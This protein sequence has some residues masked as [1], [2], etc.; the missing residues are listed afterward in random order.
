[1]R[2]AGQVPRRRTLSRR[3]PR[4]QRTT[5]PRAVA[6]HLI[7]EIKHGRLLPGQRLP[8]EKAL[9]EEFG[10]GRSSI[11]E[12]LQ[13]LVILGLADAKPGYGY[14]IKQFDREALPDV[15]LIARLLAE[16]ALLDLL[17]A[18]EMLEIPV[19]QLAAKRADTADLQAME[20]LLRE[21]EA[22]LSRGQTVHREAARFHLLVARAAKNVT[23]ERWVAS[24]IPLLTARG[25][26]IEHDIPDRSARELLLHRR[27]YDCIKA[28]D[29]AA[30]ESAMIEHLGDTRATILREQPLSTGVVGQ[31]QDG[32][33]LA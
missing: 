19:A 9:M 32:P 22:K 33:P 7:A 1:V 28:H 14:R 20:Q 30:A 11:R 29:V 23:L 13:H 27:L 15:E 24:I 8:T 2:P 4:L 17:E 26:Q 18:R 10:V 25:W 16:D 3:R 6:E 31:E 5:L 12:A 21:M